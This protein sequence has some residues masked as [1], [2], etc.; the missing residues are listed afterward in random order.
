[1]KKVDL[2][3]AAPHVYTMSGAGVGYLACGAVASDRGKIVA[4]G[5]RDEILSQYEAEQIEDRENTVLLPG[6]IDAHMHISEC[7]LR[8]LAQDTG[9]WMMYGFGPFEKGLTPRVRELGIKLALIEGIRAGTTTFGE[10]GLYTEQ[11]CQQIKKIGVRGNITVKV[12]EAVERIYAPE[13]LYE[14][15]LEY[16][17]RTMEEARL[18]FD[19]WHGSLDGRIRLVFGPQGA[20]FLSRD[21]LL[22]VKA[23][24]ERRGARIQ[25][26]TQQGDRETKQIVK[27]YGMRPVEWLDSI[28]FLDNRLQAVHLTDACEEEAALVARRG[29]SLIL[30]SGSIG[31]IDGVVPPAKAFQDAGG[32]VA[33]GSDQAPGN[34]CHNVFN[35]MKLTAL[36]NKIRYSDPEVMPAWRVLRM[37][38]IEGASALGLDREI[39]SL[40][41]GKRADMILVDL[42]QPAM[43]PIYTDPMRNIVPNLVYAASGQEV[44]LSV[45]EGQVIYRDGC[46]LGIDEKEVLKEC[47]EAAAEVGADCRELFWSVNGTNAEFMRQDKL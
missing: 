9:Y 8:G 42:D 44:C 40:E 35:E 1:M 18:L 23:E 28:G 14:F 46:I 43:T 5:P 2:I 22:A 3:V 25:M 32:C 47:R 37:A 41:P 30:C 33:L 34:N 7:M 15:S 36:F 21:R 19:R 12:R 45:V 16:G 26:H 6:L 27:R 13:E 20:D 10:S 24:A 38:T 31:I 11:V 39:G 4:V 29:A 17:D